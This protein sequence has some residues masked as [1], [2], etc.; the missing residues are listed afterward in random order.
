MNISIYVKR[1]YTNNPKAFEFWKL[2]L[3][4]DCSFTAWPLPSFGLLQIGSHSIVNAE[5]PE[6]LR[7]VRK[8][9]E[10]RQCQDWEEH[11]QERGRMKFHCTRLADGS[12]HVQNRAGHY[13]AQ[14]HMHNAMEF[15]TWKSQ[16]MAEGSRE[17]DF[18]FA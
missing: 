15:E 8:L 17:S 18:I 5:W 4:D 7:V 12:I 2:E 3:H 6:G 9:K 13:L 14:E 11:A 10:L 1:A 16:A